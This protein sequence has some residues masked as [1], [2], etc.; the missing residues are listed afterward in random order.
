MSVVCDIILCFYDYKEGIIIII[1][2]YKF[3]YNNYFILF[4]VNGYLYVKVVSY[5]IYDVSVL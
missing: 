3:Y 1:K 4:E 5:V 2:F